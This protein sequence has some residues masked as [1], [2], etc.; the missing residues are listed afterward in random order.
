MAV[1]T[2]AEDNSVEHL[3]GSDEWIDGQ[4]LVEGER[5]ER[6]KED[7]KFCS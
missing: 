4:S 2:E 7:A 1:T 6:I 3:Q 5:E